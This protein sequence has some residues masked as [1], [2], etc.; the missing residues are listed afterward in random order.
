MNTADYFNRMAEKWDDMFR[1]D[2]GVINHILDKADIKPDNI[3]LDCGTGTGTLLPYYAERLTGNGWVDAYD[4]STGMLNKAHE[5]YAST[6][7]ARFILGDIERDT[8]FGA[9][10]R[11]VMFCMLPHLNDPVATVAKLVDNNLM[12][13]GKLLIAFSCSKEKINSCHRDITGMLRSHFLDSAE[14]LAT[15]LRESGLTTDYTE[16]N[17]SCYIIRITNL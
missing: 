12:P 11:I 6:G 10:D 8:L 13:D 9:Y 17:D 3:I 7:K 1:V 2:P 14:E 4:I 5:K 16:D 15:R